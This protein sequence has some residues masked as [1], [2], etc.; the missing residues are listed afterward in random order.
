VVA[1]IDEP[2]SSPLTQQTVDQPRA[3]VAESRESALARTFGSL[4][5]PQF[6]LF[7]LSNLI[8]AMGLMV[9]VVAQRW[10][11]VQLTDS[12][13]LLGL[14]SGVWA[15]T[16]ALSSVPMGLAA[17]RSNRRN[18]LLIGSVVALLVTVV[19]AI[20]VAA[21]VVEVWH[22]L[23]AGAIGGVLFAL[24]V[25]AGQAMTARLV[26]PEQLMNAISLNQTSHSLPSV[27][28]PAAGGV[29][30][31]L[32]GVAGAYFLTSGA[33]F[34]GLLLMLGVAASFGRIQRTT[35]VSAGADLREAITYLRAHRDLLMLTAA[36]LIP[37]TLG[38]SYVLLLPLFVEQELGL[39]PVT[40]GVLSACLGAGSVLG[41]LSVAAF[42]KEKHLGLLM[43]AGILATGAAAI[44]Y[45]L[46]GSVLV[47]GA[48]L[49]AAGAGE[50]ALFAAYE[51]VLLIRLP[52]AIRGRVLG[53]MFTLVA[54]FPIGAVVAGGAADAFG[55]RA[56]AVAEGIMIIPMAF[57]AWIVVLRD[58]SA[59]CAGST[60]S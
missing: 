44:V 45:G 43:F 46:S 50:S 16:F 4:A 60:I 32:I 42:G 2:A 10:L 40:F 39:G 15:V 41:A 22:V 13:L 55:L 58:A 25:P 49:F 57:V 5:Y 11:V 17:D 59:R 18:L 33:L 34:I 31:G 36:M 23:A 21:S 48:V 52:D 35:R 53:L 9:Q 12:A 14:V 28:G 51:T 37:F 29:L 38:Q 54:L 27:A 47:V 8:V 19:V 1:Q 6:R 26:P 3:N 56:V 24:R 20:L 30:V 7:W